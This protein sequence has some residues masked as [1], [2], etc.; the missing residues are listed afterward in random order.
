MRDEEGSL[1]YRWLAQSHMECKIDLLFCVVYDDFMS[2]E[3]AGQ[4]RRLGIPMI[5]YHV[6]MQHQ[7]YRVLRSAPYFDLL[8]CAQTEYME[9]LA[10]YVKT[11]FVPFAANPEYFRPLSVPKSVDVIFVGSYS[12]ERERTLTAAYE[13]TK[14]VVVYGSGWGKTNLHQE[15]DHG[16]RRIHGLSFRLHRVYKLISD[17]R[18]Y[19]I[20]RL[21]T[22]GVTRLLK[23]RFERYRVGCQGK[24]YHGEVRGEVCDEEFVPVVSAARIALGINQR[25]GQ[26]GR[27]SDR[28]IGFISGRLRD[29]EMPSCGVMYLAQRYPE[30]EIYYREGEEI[31][32]WSTLEEMQRKLKFYLV[33]EEQRAMV[34]RRGR[35]RILRDH[36]WEIRFKHI[37]HRL[38]LLPRDA[39]QE[40]QLS[41]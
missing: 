28:E 41:L 35:Q 10:R 5:N 27:N 7:W 25:F 39:T 12:P 11:A 33:N 19:L 40:M 4:V 16:G 32:G 31:E 17:I 9:V 36:T 20:P 26:I 22:E 18:G 14:S 23:T 37:L 29:C 2:A 13:V 15:Q 38:E 30:L 21:W 3:L 34:A 24:R 1:F 6:D 8:C